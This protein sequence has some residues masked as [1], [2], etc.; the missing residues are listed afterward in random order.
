MRVGGSEFVSLQDV[1]KRPMSDFEIAFYGLSTD[2]PKMMCEMGN[3]PSPD[4]A[5][6]AMPMP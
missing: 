4:P 2:R 5:R 3:S 6:S 1:S